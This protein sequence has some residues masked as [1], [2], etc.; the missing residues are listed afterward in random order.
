MSKKILVIDN[1]QDILELISFILQEHGYK[2]I[3]SN[4]TTILD[5]VLLIR[6][7]LI[8]LDDWP[9]RREGNQLCKTLKDDY[10]TSY[11]P[12]IILSTLDG[13]AEVATECG[14]D[15]YIQKPFDIKYLI[16]VVASI[17]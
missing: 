9:D 4:S 8:L 1:D 6:P 3:V 11:I 14:A 12:V 10:N 15:H 2:L 17:L 13:L 7:D 16:E 5:D